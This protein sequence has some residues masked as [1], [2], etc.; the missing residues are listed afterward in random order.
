MSHSDA[1]V[2]AQIQKKGKLS[3]E[4]CQL[5]SGVSLLYHVLMKTLITLLFAC[6]FG[7]AAEQATVICVRAAKT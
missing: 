7:S 2:P 1:V 5:V 6:C 3:Y 4:K